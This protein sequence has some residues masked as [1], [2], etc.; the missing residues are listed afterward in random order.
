MVQSQAQNWR[1]HLVIIAKING[2]G[3]SR[4]AEILQ[5]HLAEAGWRVDIAHAEERSF[6]RRFLNTQDYDVALHLETF[7][8]NWVNVAP[9]QY[10]IPN[11][12]WF[13]ASRLRW[14]RYVDQ[15]LTKTHQAADLFAPHASVIKLL[16]FTSED[17]YDPAIPKDWN[18]FF[19]LAGASFLKGTE[20]LLSLWEKHPEWPELLLIQRDS[21]APATLPQN[22]RLISRYVSDIELREF[23]NRAGVHLCPSKSE[24]WGHH[25][26]EAMST[27]ALVITTDAP[28]MNEFITGENGI[29]VPYD[30]KEPRKLSQN[31][32][33]SEP[34]MEATIERILKMP[35]S[36]K[37]AMGQRARASF[38]DIDQQFRKRLPELLH[39]TPSSHSSADC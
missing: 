22:V 29:C 9:Q 12:E 33:V 26:V 27:G 1:D 3:L 36:E 5:R 21:N 30:R 19:H 4:D 8:P 39:P 32:F 24:G 14:L 17:R 13:R 6:L 28:P 25:L 11:P 31:Y 2:H 37:A 20:T 7:H 10:L 38:L 18:G 23:Q 15:V 35:V 34:A 16:G